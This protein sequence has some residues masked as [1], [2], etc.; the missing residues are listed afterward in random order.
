MD[1][2]YIFRYVKDKHGQRRG[3]IVAV[4]KNKIGWSL[5]HTQFS[6]AFDYVEKLDTFDKE[7]GL[8]CSDYHDPNSHRNYPVEFVIKGFDVKQLKEFI[9]K[10]RQEVR[11]ATLSECLDII[12]HSIDKADAYKEIT[13][14]LENLKSAPEENKL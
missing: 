12:N 4:D 7:F 8:K 10:D 6:D 5:C 2:R 14:I 9:T 3:I 13:Q 1:N 11:K